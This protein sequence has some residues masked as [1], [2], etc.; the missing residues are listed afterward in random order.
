[1]VAPEGKEDTTQNEKKKKA[2][3]KATSLGKGSRANVISPEVEKV[4]EKF[5]KHATESGIEALRGESR[6]V[7]E[8]KPNP[9]TYEKFASMPDRNRFPEIQCLD[10]TRVVLEQSEPNMNTYIHASR[11]K[12]DKTGVSTIFVFLR[13]WK[14]KAFATLLAQTSFQPTEYSVSE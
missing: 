3:S 5:V 12:M 8:F 1:M 4:V 2:P 14:S 10:E 9:G 13:A 11:V 6:D 7:L